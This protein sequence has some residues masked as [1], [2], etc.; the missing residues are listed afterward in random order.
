MNKNKLKAKDLVSLAIF[1]VVFIAVYMVCAIPTGLIVPLYPFCVG[2]AMIPCGIV[3]AYLRA[4]APKPIAT[5]IQGILFA[6]IVFIMGSGWFVSTG[7]FAGAVLAELFARIGAY[8][9]FKWNAV[10]YAAFAVCLNLGLFGIILFA[11]DYYYNFC[12][13]SG[14][15]TEYME[16]LIDFVTGPLLALSCALAVVGAVVGM[17]LGRVLLKKHFVKAGIV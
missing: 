14:M 9:S 6:V 2:I 7:V 15:A 17:L 13:E 3:W 1:S 16:A 5:L 8:K 12:I 4:K 10:G 11:R